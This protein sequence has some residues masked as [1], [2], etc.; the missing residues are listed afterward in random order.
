VLL[1]LDVEPCEHIKA[2]A[3]SIGSVVDVMLY[4]ETLRLDVLDVL[5]HSQSDSRL[6]TLG[7]SRV[8][9]A[10]QIHK[11]KVVKKGIF[12][13]QTKS[14]LSDFVGHQVEFLEVIVMNERP[15]KTLRKTI[16]KLV[17]A[18]DNRP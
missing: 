11:R 4:R 2:H 1:G 12:Q 16:P 8:Y 14:V 17:T 15:S 10:V 13:N 3:H 7:A 18:K 5:A 9:S 6:Y